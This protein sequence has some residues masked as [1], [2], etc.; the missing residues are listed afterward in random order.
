M[1]WDRI[2]LNLDLHTPNGLSI[3]YAN[4]KN[5]GPPFYLE[6]FFARLF[7]RIPVGKEAEFIR[8]FSEATEFDLYDVKHFLEQIPEE[9]KPRMAVRSSLG[10][11]LKKLC[12]LYC[13]E[14]NKNLYYETFPLQLASELSGI[15]ESDLI[16]VVV[17]AIGEKD[18]TMSPERLFALV[19]LLAAQ[20][21]LEEALDVLNFGL[22]LF[23]DALD[24]DHGDGPW[25]DALTPPRDINESIAGYIWAAL[26]APQASLRW[27]AAHVV[28]GLC[29]LGGQAVLDHLVEL[30]QSRSGGPFADRRL[31]F[32]HLHARQWLM[33]ALARAASE[34]P[35]TLVSHSDFF[36]HFALN[37]EPHAVIRHFAAKAALALAESGIFQLD[38][39]IAVQLNSINSS[40]LPVVLSK[41]YQR[42]QDHHDEDDRT[43]RFSFDYDISRYWFGRLGDC[44][45][46][47]ASF[48]ENEAEKVI[49]DDW[50][51][52]E[53]GRWDNDERSRRNIFNE[54]ETRHS[55][56][57][58]PR[59]D[60]LSFYLSYHAMMTVAG[61]LLATIPLHQD[62]DYSEDEFESWLSRHLL[63]RQDGYWLADRRD[64]MPLE[65]PSWKNEK[66]E[67]DWRWSVCRSDFDHLLGLGEDRL[68]LWGYWNTVFGQREEKV[69]V[70]SALVSPDRS[71]SLLRALQTATDSY[72]YRIPDASDYGGDYMAIDE[73]GFQLKGWVENFSSDNALDEFDPWAGEIQY[74]PLKPAKFVRDLFHLEEDREC[75]IWRSRTKS[76]T[77]E[78][79]W[80][81][82]WGSYRRQDDE[83]EGEGGQRLQAS[84]TF[85]TE[86]LGKMNMDLIVEVEIER[87][88]RR[89]HY[90]RSRDEDIGHVPPYF[91]IFVIRA[92]GRTY[93]L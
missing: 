12:G 30:A 40:K 74:P 78:V 54:N 24:E 93:S 13:M 5:S 71:A 19:G 48:I 8:V 27:E 15:S 67:D 10:K 57:A 34:N 70:S 22:G 69:R 59:T 87:S 7:K 49:C 63:S 26:A 56:G 75:R 92:D 44:F 29:K 85:V 9:W 1:D 77:K 72:S 81:Q 45:T 89:M 66:T 36:I 55:H 58:Y 60:D 80:S 42:N 65:W 61:K 35:A 84:Q 28:R 11:A 68:N 23:D 47:N 82:V 76:G 39:N 25:T 16:S 91:R 90:E 32:Y 31:H 88:I 79:I 14:I 50:Q 6:T 38:K 41:R 21:S 43:K 20:L 2:F 83:S 86:F 33:I 37:D 46:K 62:P 53:N 52:S 17:A 3:A 64:S 18:E 51:F 73:S 4:F